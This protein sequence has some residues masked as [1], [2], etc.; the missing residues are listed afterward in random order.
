MLSHLAEY[1]LCDDERKVIKMGLRG[2]N[3]E[4]NIWFDY[5]LKGNKYVIE[6]SLAF[7]DEEGSDMLHMSIKTSVDLKQQIEMLDLFQ[8]MFKEL[9]E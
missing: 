3:D 9:I 5:S 6:L 7:D 8:A 4:K 2:T 1:D